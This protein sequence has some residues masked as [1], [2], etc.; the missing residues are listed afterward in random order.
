MDSFEFL[1]R[2]VAIFVNPA[3]LIAGG[4]IIALYI[5][6]KKYKNST[7]CKVTNRS[8]FSVRF[9]KGLY[10]EYLTYDHLRHMESSGAKFLFNLYIPKGNGEFTEIDMLMICSKGILV[11][12]SKNYSGWIFGSEHKKNWCQTLPAG[13]GKSHKEYF[14]NPIMQ[15]CAHIKHLKALLNEQ[16]PMMSIIVFS[17]RCTLKS[18]QVSCD[19]VYVVKRSMVTNIVS[20]LYERFP[21]DPLNEKRISEIHSKL[22]PFTQ[23]NEVTRTQ[24]IANV[25]NSLNSRVRPSGRYDSTASPS[26]CPRCNGNLV[27]R[28]STR[29]KNIGNHFYGCANYPKCRY[30][31]NTSDKTV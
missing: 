1:L 27:L 3:T 6:N 25:Q 9:N 18:I 23:M 15:N 11:F 10:G 26:R 7:Y 13:R 5:E 2:L 17:D 31:Q 21:F 20:A 14:Y 4:I 19:D 30:T 12:E 16:I 28:T 24:H 29:G 8:F 22:Y